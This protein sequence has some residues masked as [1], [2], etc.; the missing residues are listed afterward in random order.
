[1]TDNWQQH[2]ACRHSD[3]RIFFE[4]SRTPEPARNICKT[5]PVKQ[6]CLDTVMREEAVTRYRYGI[7]AGLTP[8]QRDQLAGKHRKWTAA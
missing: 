7:F 6:Q 4:D 5:C 2:A 1:M 3:T 8:N